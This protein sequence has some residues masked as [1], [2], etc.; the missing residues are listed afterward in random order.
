MIIKYIIKIIAVLLIITNISCSQCNNE[1]FSFWNGERISFFDTN[2][3][4]I[5]DPLG[6]IIIEYFR[7]DQNSEIDFIIKDYSIDENS[8][9]GIWHIET[10]SNNIISNCLEKDCNLY[11]KFNNR[12]L[13]DTISM[14]INKVVK[15]CCTSHVTNNFSFNST[16]AMK[17]STIGGY[18]IIVQ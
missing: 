17:E 15:D 12:L 16:I 1:C 4:N 9:E 6:G 7:T 10:V 13:P 2:G 14:S 11:I 5:L 3:S 8:P 18:K